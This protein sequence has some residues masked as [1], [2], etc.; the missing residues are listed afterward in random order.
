VQPP[1]ASEKYTQFRGHS[2]RNHPSRAVQAPSKVGP[3]TKLASPSV[4]GHKVIKVIARR[5]QGIREFRARFDVDEH[6]TI[7]R[8]RPSNRARA[9][10]NF[11][12]VDTSDDGECLRVIS[13]GQ[14]ELSLSSGHDESP[15]VVVRLS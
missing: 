4:T 1:T 3:T 9:I 8:K 14:R 6:S 5:I 2:I 12:L 10:R 13:R 15:E 7:P 11:K